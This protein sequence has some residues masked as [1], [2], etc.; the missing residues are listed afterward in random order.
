MNIYLCL[1]K[2]ADSYKL[3]INKLLI[4]W[5]CN[6]FGEFGKKDMLQFEAVFIGN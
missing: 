1:K 4:W 3:T 6:H 2:L 5:W